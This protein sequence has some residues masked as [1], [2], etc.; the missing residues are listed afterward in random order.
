MPDFKNREQTPAV[1]VGE[2]READML[3]GNISHMVIKLAGFGE[4][5][6]DLVLPC[7]V[8]GHSARLDYVWTSPDTIKG[9]PI[10]TL[11][12]RWYGDICVTSIWSVDVEAPSLPDGTPTVDTFSTDSTGTQLNVERHAYG[13]HSG[14]YAGIVEIGTAYN[15]M[16]NTADIE[17]LRSLHSILGA[18]INSAES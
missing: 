17:R 5:V 10:P 14:Y 9:L 1:E 8:N 18:A 11:S 16:N 2:P 15:L 4:E 7:E 6:E 3:F 13:Q 12:V